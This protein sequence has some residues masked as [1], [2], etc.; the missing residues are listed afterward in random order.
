VS[1]PTVAITTGSAVQLVTVRMLGTFL[2]TVDPFTGVAAVIQNG[3]TAPAASYHA[4]FWLIVAL[5]LAALFPTAFLGRSGS[6]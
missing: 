3:T 1:G 4:A 6:S 2:P 5:C